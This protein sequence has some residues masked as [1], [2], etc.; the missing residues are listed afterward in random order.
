[1]WTLLTTT[2]AAALADSINPIAIAQQMLLQSV[3]R[4]K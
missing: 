3:S 1:M 2:V 4:K